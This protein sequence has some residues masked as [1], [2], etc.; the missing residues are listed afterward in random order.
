MLKWFKTVAPIRAKFRALT[1]AVVVLGM[2]ALLAT[3][4]LSA[5]W[6]SGSV[7][8]AISGAISL[9]LLAIL[10]TAG[11]L[12][13]D[14]YV[15]IVVRIEALVAGDTATPIDFT[16]YGD[17]V[18]RLARAMV[19]CRGN[20]LEI[21]R[22]QAEQQ[23]VVQ[24]L[25]SALKKLADNR[26]GQ[27]IDTAF[28]ASYE[29]LRTDFN[30][31]T[32]SLAE[33]ICTVRHSADSV[34][35]G[36]SEIHTAAADLAQ[37]NEMQAAS[38]EET[39]AALNT[40][41]QGVTH[42]ARMASDGE[43]AASLAHAEATAG[44]ESV[45][46]AVEA[47]DRIERTSHEISQI[48]TLID[49]ITFQTNLLALNAGVEAARAGDAG[50][51]FAVVASEIRAL[52]QRSAAASTDIKALITTSTQ[53]VN[54]GVA[55]VAQVGTL[56]QQIVTRVGEVNGLVAS[57]ATSA[58]DQS[59]ALQQVNATAGDMDRVT[60]QNAAMVE[61]T[62]AAARSLAD[63]AS[64]L[65]S[66]VARFEVNGGGGDRSVVSL[67]TAPRMAPTAPQ[68]RAAAFASRQFRGQYTNSGANSG[69]RGK[70]R[71]QQIPGTA[72]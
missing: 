58:H 41:T 68:G 55:L 60:Q 37:R 65:A 63:E 56:L 57:I 31:A 51:G 35:T 48:I 12:I 3:C 69:D 6:V 32:S 9:S 46:S 5:G 70:F 21:E 1:I 27:Q 72:Y 61:E 33:A 18:G 30:R 24:S 50:K 16:E 20:V 42:S 45:K 34:L 52:A 43:K 23:V 14:P 8:I 71:G 38:L 22:S 11:R 44:G 17:C 59:T 29:E 64:E 66:V 10:L 4:G 53:Q 47:M 7:A 15:N 26:L 40:V 28:P 13:C 49:G 54:S 19:K 62:S 67:R 36:S 25:S 39:T 2:V